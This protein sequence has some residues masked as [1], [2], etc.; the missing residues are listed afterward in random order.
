VFLC[1]WRIF[2]VCLALE[3]VGSCVV[4]GFSVGMEAFDELLS[5][6]VPWSQGLD[7]SLLL[8][9]ISLIFTVVSK[10]L[11][12]YSTIDKTSRLKMKSFS[13]MRVTQ[14]G[15]QCYMEKRRGRREL[16]VTQM[17][18]GGINRGESGLTSN[19]FLMCTPQ[20]DCSEMFTEL[21]REEKREEG[22]RGG[23]EDKR[24]EWKGERQIQPVISSLSVLHRL[25]HT[26]IQSWVE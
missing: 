2:L 3:I 26:E 8:P 21:Y 20:L 4:L 19:H 9:V 12:L 15:S 10:L 14:R 5:I 23:Q 18:W 16:E 24:R 6:N 13:T 1:C 25:E 22:D 17:R 11:L 7:L